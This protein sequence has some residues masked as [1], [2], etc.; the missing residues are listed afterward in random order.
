VCAEPCSS[1]IT[2]ST[3]KVSRTCCT[4]PNA[5]N[6]HSNVLP[7]FRPSSVPQQVRHACTLQ[8]L[9]YGFTLLHLFYHHSCAAIL[10][11]F[12]NLPLLLC[13]SADGSCP[14]T[15]AAAVL[16]S[17]CVQ[18]GFDHAFFWRSQAC[19]GTPTEI[20]QGRVQRG[21]TPSSC[22]AVTAHQTGNYLEVALFWVTFQ[23]GRC[24]CRALQT[25]SWKVTQNRVTPQRGPLRDRQTVHDYSCEI[26]TCQ[27][28]GQAGT[29]AGLSR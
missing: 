11:Y 22:C 19:P 21:L 3:T 18:S 9:C 27:G 1:T 28:Y 4:E 20:I 26:P 2:F 10:R 29:L 17:G 16:P 13:T 5:D 8:Q 15:A 7:V 23:W 6:H 24:S 14:R 12:K 25:C